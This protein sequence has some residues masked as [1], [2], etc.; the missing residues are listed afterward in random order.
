MATS[1]LAPATFHCA[2]RSA[3][4]RGQKRR[5]LLRDVL[6]AHKV[7]RRHTWR[8][9]TGFDDALGPLMQTTF[10][11]PPP[12]PSELP[13]LRKAMLQSLLQ[14]AQGKDEL[15]AVC[16]HVAKWW[17]SRHLVV[18]QQLLMDGLVGL[19]LAAFIDRVPSDEKELAKHWTQFEAGICLLLMIVAPDHAHKLTKDLTSALPLALEFVSWEAFHILVAAGGEHSDANDSSDNSIAGDA[20]D[21]SDGDGAAG[22]PALPS[23]SSA[24]KQVAVAASAVGVWLGRAK[25]HGFEELEALTAAVGGHHDVIEQPVR[26]FKADSNTAN[27][28]VAETVDGHAANELPAAQERFQLAEENSANDDVWASFA[29]VP[30]DFQRDVDVS[31]YFVWHNPYDRHDKVK[32]FNRKG[33][34]KVFLCNDTLQLLCSA[35]VLRWDNDDGHLD[36]LL[37]R[38]GHI[39]HEDYDPRAVGDQRPA[40]GG[41]NSMQ[42]E[43]VHLTTANSKP[44]IINFRSCSMTL[45]LPPPS[46]A[47][48]VGSAA[49][50]FGTLKTTDGCDTASA[51]GFGLTNV[52]R[53]DDA[54][55]HADDA[56]GPL[57]FALGT[58][59]QQGAV[60]KRGAGGRL[61]SHG[62]P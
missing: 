21:A 29:A 43:L 52:K 24:V 54:V 4:A 37:G 13:E 61:R 44:L 23:T 9:S 45:Q 2:H 49:V 55:V 7:A 11:P 53:E 58:G 17:A 47:A 33:A 31:S 28:Q 6:A 19:L 8:L 56:E 46:E 1:A 40:A 41:N 35:K 22:N 51:L 14:W 5:S 60:H 18:P 42:Y 36:A 3:D 10:V 12:P 25:E 59:D 20:S 27:H 15:S 32:I 62:V 50:I 39:G 48:W 34:G 38:N 26:L 16:A 30:S 57:V